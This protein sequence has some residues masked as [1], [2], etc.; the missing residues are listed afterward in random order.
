[1]STLVSIGFRIPSSLCQECIK[2]FHQCEEFAFPRTLKNFTVVAGIAW[3]GEECVQA[4]ERIDHDDLMTQLL[5]KGQS[6][7]KPALLDLLDALVS[8]YLEKELWQGKEFKTL[9]EKILNSLTE[10][11]T[12]K[13]EDPKIYEALVEVSGSSETPGENDLA[14]QWIDEAGSNF[15][16]LALR[17]TLAVFH[18]TPFELIER[19]KN[20]LLER[21]QDLM[22]PPSPPSEG[23]QPPPANH[24]PLMRRIEIAGAKEIPGKAPDWRKVIELNRP[25]A[26]SKALSYFWQ[27][28]RESKWRQK[29]I[30]WLTEYAAGYAV[31]VRTR[32][33]VAAGRLAVDDYRFVRDK[34]LAVWVKQNDSEY[35]MAVG[36]ALGVLVR[37]E[38]LVSE[39]QDL[40]SKWSKSAEMD[41]RWA[42]VRAY[43]YV[44]AYLSA[45]EV[46]ASWR[47]IA[48][49]ELMG[50]Y[51]EISEDKVL[52]LR[53]PLYMSLMDAMMRFF[54]ETAQ[55]PIEEKRRL[56]TG[57]LAGLRAWMTADK[58]DPGLGIFM[59]ST[60]SRLVVNPLESNGAGGP[61]VL[62]ELIDDAQSDYKAELLQ[63][64]N[65]LMS[66]GNTI[67]E[68]RDLLCRW[69]SWINALKSDSQSHEKRLQNLLR[70]I[71]EADTSGRMRGRLT[72]CL[73]DCGRKA[74]VE[75]ILSDL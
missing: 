53:N 67:M 15:D 1:M 57:I 43:I 35:R 64:F 56:F 72:R 18:G 36:M 13:A 30:E 52:L 42:A 6:Q 59:F 28:Y 63:L 10:A 48:S 22:P 4:A 60:L 49:S 14:R 65:L 71:I 46:I 37:E 19:A 3:I 70:D 75:R 23:T 58:G 12:E 26:A 29:V 74:V 38:S 20:D 8:R 73:R 31:D 54:V 51:V 45:S 62:F 17:V 39:V 16:E 66:N 2:L 32:V 47:D 69:V 33:A 68:V 9:K 24:V 44:G 5:T 27:L 11:E 41:E 34:L 40:L 21:L 25:E 7:S 55:R 61:P 50:V